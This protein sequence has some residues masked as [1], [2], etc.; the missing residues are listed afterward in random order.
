MLFACDFCCD[1]V[2][3]VCNFFVISR[4]VYEKKSV[5]CPSIPLTLVGQCFSGVVT[6]G[7]VYDKV[8]R[9]W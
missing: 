5:I 2:I 7:G 8:I 4:K 3:F 1:F 6:G 9:M